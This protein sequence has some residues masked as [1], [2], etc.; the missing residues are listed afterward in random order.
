MRTLNYLYVDDAEI[1]I[2]SAAKA[3]NSDEKLE[4]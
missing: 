2:Q 3:D 4:I 1:E